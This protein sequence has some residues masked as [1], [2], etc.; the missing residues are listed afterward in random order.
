MIVNVK[1]SD[2][3]SQIYNGVVTVTLVTYLKLLEIWVNL[4]KSVFCSH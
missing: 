1:L 3:R 4:Y 2:C